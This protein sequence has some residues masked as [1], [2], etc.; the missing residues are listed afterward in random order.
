MS[1]LREQ[2]PIDHHNHTFGEMVSTTTIRVEIGPGHGFDRSVLDGFF[3]DGL[4]G[5]FKHAD[6]VFALPTDEEGT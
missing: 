3:P 6:F 5:E 2:W 1:A 4:P